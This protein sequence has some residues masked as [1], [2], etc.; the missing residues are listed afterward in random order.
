MENIENEHISLYRPK[1]KSKNYYDDEILGVWPDGTIYL[2]E[3]VKRLKYDPL[4]EMVEE[5]YTEFKLKMNNLVERRESLKMEEND[6][7]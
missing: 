2:K 4:E 5:A 7:N 6:F 1:T 3:G